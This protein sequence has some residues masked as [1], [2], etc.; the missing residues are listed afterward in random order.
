MDPTGVVIAQPAGELRLNQRC[1]LVLP[2]TGRRWLVQCEE[3]GDLLV[4][5]DRL[6]PIWRLQVPAAAGQGGIHAVAEDLSLVA[7]SLQEQVLLLD[8]T[9]QQVAR[10]SRPTGPPDQGCCVFAGD[11]WHLWATVASEIPERPWESSDEL[12]L[13][14]LAARSVA[15]RRRLDTGAAICLPVHHPDGQTIGLFLGEAEDGGSGLY[16]ARADR[17][18]IS[19]RHGLGRDRILVD[20]HPGGDEY[21]TTPDIDA[22]AANELVRHRFVDNQPIDALALPST[23]AAGEEVWWDYDAGYL[24]DELI[25]AGTTGA[26]RDVHVLVQRQP[27]RL[28]DSIAY[29]GGNPPGWLRC[30]QDGGW[31][32]VGSER[33]Q[34]WLLPDQPVRAGQSAPS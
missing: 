11:G 19:L 3:A 29:P 12:W 4:V 28:L 23:D 6:Q 27:L 34:R 7:L 32:T 22:G 1:D 17:G 2:M 33:I 24:T 21:L 9:G 5:D 25:L 30:S 20:V 10:L 14:D 26:D 31:L 16:W 15:D 8:G 18:R 13:I